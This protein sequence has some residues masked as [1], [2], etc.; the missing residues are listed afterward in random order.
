MYQSSPIE[1][2]IRHSTG[3]VTLSLTSGAQLTGSASVHERTVTLTTTTL[4]WTLA[5]S[6]VVAVGEV[7][8][9]RPA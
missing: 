5:L 2:R 4:V 7:R 3:D 8:H 9:D 1:H 6:S